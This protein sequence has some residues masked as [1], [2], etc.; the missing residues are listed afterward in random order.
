MISASQY[1]S[2]LNTYFVQLGYATFRRSDE[3]LYIYRPVDGIDFAFGLGP[4]NPDYKF[5][6]TQ[7]RDYVRVYAW[8]N[9]H[10]AELGRIDLTVRLRRVTH[11]DCVCDVE[12]LFDRA[13]VPH[14]EA[15]MGIR[16]LVL[17]SLPLKQTAE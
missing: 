17:D 15:L 13:H 1:L 8:A 16:N 3:Y 11:A 5:V 9:E 6:L 2:R 14:A 10:S 12:V 7:R 4:H